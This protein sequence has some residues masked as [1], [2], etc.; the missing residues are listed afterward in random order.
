MI[1]IHCMC[2]YEIPVI[3]FT[4][5]AA[6]D[7]PAHWNGAPILFMFAAATF[8]CLCGSSLINGK[9]SRGLTHF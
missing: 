3:N 2:L 9:C 6:N 8:S 5:R 4:A 1:R 7:D